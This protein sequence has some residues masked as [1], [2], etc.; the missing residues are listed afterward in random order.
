VVF[1]ERLRL[2]TV[3]SLG[4]Y[5]ISGRELGGNFIPH[6]FL[7]LID[8]LFGFLLLLSGQFLLL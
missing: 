7:F 2:L 3:V 4:Y 6:L 1:V 5:L 8:Q